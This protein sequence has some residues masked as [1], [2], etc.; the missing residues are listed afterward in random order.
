MYLFVFLQILFA[1]DYS[2][3]EFK[4]WID[5]DRDCQNTRHELLIERSLIEVKFKDK[6]SCQVQ[7]GKWNDFYFDEVM[8]S[9]KDV[10]IDHIVPLKHAWDSGAKYWNSS[11]KKIFANDPEN[12]VLTNKKYNRQ[13]GAKTILE[14][15][16]IKRERACLYAKKWISVKEKYELS[17]SKE[18]LNHIKLLNC[19]NLHH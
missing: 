14:W 13:K 7:F 5:V 2:R 12:L 16:P 10:D 4:H 17:I 1:S 18:E 19:E 6:K 11:K 3:K 8:T 9:A 15:M